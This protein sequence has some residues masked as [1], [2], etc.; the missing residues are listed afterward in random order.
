M[1][2]SISCDKLV[3]PILT[4]SSG[5][6]SLI[7]SDSGTNSIGKSSVL[8]IIDFCFGGNDFIKTSSDVFE[9]VGHL[10]ITF[11]FEFDNCTYSFRRSTANPGVV[12]FDNDIENPKT[13]VNLRKFLKQKYDVP[14]PLSF[15]DTVNLTSRIWGKGNFNP[16]RPLNFDDSK[17][18]EPI[19]KYLMSL[20]EFYEEVSNK[21]K[22]KSVLESKKTTI[23]NAFDQNLIAKKLYKTELPTKK[24]E[25]AELEEKIEE[26]KENLAK[27]TTNINEVVNQR[28]LLIKKEKDVLLNKLNFEEMRLIRTEKSL[29]FGTFA[30]KRQF[31]K[32]VN[33][34]PDVNLEK[35]THIESFHS[36]ITK[37]LKNEISAEKSSIE[38][39]ILEY[40]E[41]INFLDKSLNEAF[42]LKDNP[43]LLVDDL[44]SMTIFAKELKEQIEYRELSDYIDDNVKDIKKVSEELSK[45][46]LDKVADKLFHSMK[47]FIRSIYEDPAVPYFTFAMKNYTFNPNGDTGTG[48]CFS[49][50]ISFDLSL[51]NDTDLPFLIH[52]SVVLKNIEVNA[53]DNIIELYSQSKN[54]NKQVFISIDEV[55]KYSNETKKIIENSQFLTLSDTKLAFKKHWDKN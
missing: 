23:K 16:N 49:N 46:T 20:F 7:G 17:F 32:L 34:F 24:K 48:K 13:D 26:L 14:E 12:I 29:Q 47:K 38:Q 37:I 15:R 18:Y 54:L 5:L 36:G 11:E 40:R 27:Y 35:L 31:G 28:S 4:F 43:S 55:S 2:K 33:F 6:N 53:V 3:K 42:R 19:T 50:M 45:V 52:D 10:D 9:Q 30:N 1:L 8:L 41:Q 39:N 51:L 22:E 21:R 44:L 25:L